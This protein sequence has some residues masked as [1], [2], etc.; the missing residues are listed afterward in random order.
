[1]DS[2]VSLLPN[3]P[4]RIPETVKRRSLLNFEMV[5]LGDMASVATRYLSADRWETLDQELSRCAVRSSS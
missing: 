4:L 5:S 1:M 2:L 3:F